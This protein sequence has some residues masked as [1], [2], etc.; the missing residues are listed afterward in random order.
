M[1]T[2]E[3]AGLKKLSKWT[4]DLRDK[5]W[6]YPSG[7]FKQTTGLTNT[8]N[9]RM[10]APPSLITMVFHMLITLVLVTM[11]LLSLAFTMLIPSS[12]IVTTLALVVIL[13]NV[14][15]TLRTV[16]ILTRSLVQWSAIS[17]GK[18]KLG[19]DRVTETGG[20]GF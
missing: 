10:E 4:P 9:M 20:E 12:K 5:N 7:I 2:Q 19:L 17:K 11:A 15:F 8:M 16:H 6:G 1:S 14:A 13:I 3:T 18:M